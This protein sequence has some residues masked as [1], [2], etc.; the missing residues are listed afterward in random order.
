MSKIN[1]DSMG[2][3]DIFMQEL[4]KQQGDQQIQSGSQGKAKAMTE[5]DWEKRFEDLL[6][7]DLINLDKGFY[8]E[9]MLFEEP[10]RLMDVF[11]QLEE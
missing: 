6:R 9:E 1:K 8:E 4:L 10:E 5:K 7:L 3:E 2:E 11:T